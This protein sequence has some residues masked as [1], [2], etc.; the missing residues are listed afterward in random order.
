MTRRRTDIDKDIGGRAERAAQRQLGGRP[1]VAVSLFLVLSS[2][3]ICD[4]STPLE[5]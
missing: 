2:S 5:M 1:F 4:A 3:F